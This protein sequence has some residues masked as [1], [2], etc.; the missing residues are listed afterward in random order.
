MKYGVRIH[1][2]LYSMLPEARESWDFL[3]MTNA[4]RQAYRQPFRSTPELALKCLLG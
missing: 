3:R 1:R 4:E 2:G